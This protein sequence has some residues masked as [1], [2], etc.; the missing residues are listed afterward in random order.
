MDIKSL[1]KGRESN[2][3]IAPGQKLF[4]YVAVS[5]TGVRSKGRMQAPN[6]NIVVE[7]L[8]SENFIPIN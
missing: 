7:S 8:Q 4:N 1:L 3:N 2:T 6:K 5:N